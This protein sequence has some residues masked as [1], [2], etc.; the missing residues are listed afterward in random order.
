MERYTRQNNA[1]NI[2]QDYFE[3]EEEE[4]DGAPEPPSAKTVNVLR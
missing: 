1:V 3:E 4:A 2:Y